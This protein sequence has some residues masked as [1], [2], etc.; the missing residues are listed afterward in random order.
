MEFTKRYDAGERV[1]RSPIFYAGVLNAD[2]TLIEGIW[3]LRDHDGRL[4]GGFRMQR[5][6]KGPKAAVTREASE[7]VLAGV[8]SRRRQVWVETRKPKKK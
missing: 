5:G 4:T 6:G 2:L 7:P 1:H 3:T 8:E